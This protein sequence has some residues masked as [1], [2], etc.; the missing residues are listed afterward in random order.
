MIFLSQHPQSTGVTGLCD[1]MPTL[2]YGCWH[3]NSGLQVL[4]TTVFPVPLVICD[5]INWYTRNMN[6]FTLSPM[7]HGGHGN[8]PECYVIYI[9]LHPYQA[10]VLGTA[11]SPESM[12]YRMVLAKEG[13]AYSI[14]SPHKKN[15][16]YA[17]LNPAFSI[18]QFCLEAKK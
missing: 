4:L 6:K 17:F 15:F 5:S 16:I 10:W 13:R 9:Q 2:I 8:I 7:L 12:R 18:G 14:G 1:T 3:Q 11:N